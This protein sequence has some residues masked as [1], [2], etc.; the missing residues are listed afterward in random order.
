[1][2]LILDGSA[3]VTFPNSTVQTAAATAVS[4]SA[5]PYAT[6]VGYQALNSNTGTNNTAIGYQALYVNTTATNSTAMGSQALYN[7]NTSYNNAFGYR[8]GYNTTTGGSN[9]YFGDRSGFSNSAGNNSTFVGTYCGYNTTGSY[10]QFF[11]TNAGYLVTTGTKNTILGSFY[12]TQTSSNNSLDITTSSNNMVLA[13]GQGIVKSWVDS[14]NTQYMNGALNSFAEPGT[15]IKSW[16][17]GTYGALNTWT[18]IWTIPQGTCG[19]LQVSINQGSYGGVAMFVISR[20]N[21]AFN[22]GMYQI[23]SGVGDM[24]GYSFAYRLSGTNNADFQVINYTNGVQ[25][26]A[27]LTLFYMS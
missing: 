14:S 9:C 27:R 13:D 1:M 5:S 22:A 23:C 10:N 24:A 20:G 15:A 21:A 12:G 18:T 6:Y 8:A 16:N 2:S 7:N 17:S 4:Q 3:G 26:Q 25:F 19:L 11:G